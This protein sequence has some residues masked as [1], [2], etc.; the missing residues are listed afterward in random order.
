M[1]L[2]KALSLVQSFS[3]TWKQ[4]LDLLNKEILSSFPS[5]LTGSS[6]LQLALAHFL[7]YYER[8]HKLLTPTVRAQF[9]NIHHIKVE[10]KKYK[11]NFS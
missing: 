3:N 1:F 6:L 10:I 2:G 11:T 4:S 7:Q 9:V 5:L 8:F